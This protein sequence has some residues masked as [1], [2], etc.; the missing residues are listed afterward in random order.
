MH[1]GQA[2]RNAYCDCGK[3]L[4]VP[5][6]DELARL[7]RVA[8]PADAPS[9]QR[10]SIPT[11]TWLGAVLAACGLIAALLVWY[12]PAPADVAPTALPQNREQIAAEVRAMSAAELLQL[13]AAIRNEGLSERRAVEEVPNTGPSARTLWGMTAVALVVVGV[14]L[15]GAGVAGRR[16]G[17]RGEA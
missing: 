17:S 10:S 13:S 15:A 3:T 4:S 5:A 16:E 12:G 2:G 1:A 8:P 9:T 6:L 11:T 14:L 7:E